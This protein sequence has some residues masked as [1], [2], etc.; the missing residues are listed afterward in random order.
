MFTATE[1][2]IRSFGIR[3]HLAA[4]CVSSSPRHGLLLTCLWINRPTESSIVLTALPIGMCICWARHK[5]SVF[6][7]IHTN[8]QSRMLTRRILAGRVDQ[9]HRFR[10]A[11]YIHGPSCM[12]SA[13]LLAR[14]RA[15][16][17]AADYHRGSEG[18]S[19]LLHQKIVGTLADGVC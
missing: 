10:I 11:V 15:I 18:G 9:A 2:R 19:G 14:I 5:T 6:L 1:Y 17:G 4:F 13:H 8:S 3:F 7:T 16:S 12:T